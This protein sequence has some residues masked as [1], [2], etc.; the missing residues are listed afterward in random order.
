M[1]TLKWARVALA[2]YCCIV[3]TATPMPSYY[4]FVVNTVGFLVTGLSTADLIK[5]LNKH[6]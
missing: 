4:G 5:D 1:I 2:L 3:V 6:Q